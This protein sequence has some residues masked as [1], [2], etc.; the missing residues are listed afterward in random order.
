MIYKRQSLSL[1]DKLN[2]MKK[3]CLHLFA[4]L[5]T[6]ILIIIFQFIVLKEN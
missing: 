1:F 3:F 5:I 6:L 2:K 4:V